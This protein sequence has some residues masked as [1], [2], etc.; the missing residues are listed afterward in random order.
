[1]NKLAI[2]FLCVFGVSFVAP[3]LSQEVTLEQG[4]ANG[5]GCGKGKN[6]K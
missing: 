3:Q 6:G 1:M 2:A 4:H 5:C